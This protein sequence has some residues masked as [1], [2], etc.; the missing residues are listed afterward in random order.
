MVTTFPRTL[1]VALLLVLAACASAP[2]QVEGEE[3]MFDASPPDAPAEAAIVMGP[4]CAPD[5][6]AT[7]GDLYRDCFGPD[8]ASCGQ[9]ACHGSETDMGARSSGFVC[10]V[11]A[12]ECWMGMTAVGSIVPSGGSETPDSTA[13]YT[14]LRKAPPG[15]GGTMPSMST[16]AFTQADLERIATWIEGGAKD[17]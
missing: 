12:E 16:F 2:S 3:P 5:G 13:L 8:H 6:G 4:S 9:P 10:G 1:V 11:T 14:A 17:D 15:S 7:W